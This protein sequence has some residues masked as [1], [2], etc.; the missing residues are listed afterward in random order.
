MKLKTSLYSKGLVI[1]N[2]KRYW[3]VSALYTLALFFAIPFNHYIQKF[4]NSFNYDSGDQEWIRQPIV[5]ELSFKGGSSQFFLLVIPIIIA[6]LVFRFMQ[7]NRSA[8]LYHSLPLT[9]TALYL[10]GVLS[11]LILFAAPILITTFIMFLLNWFSYLSAY[12]TAVLILSWLLKSLLFGIMFMSMGIFVGM[13]TGSSIAQLAFTYILNFLPMFIVESVRLNVRGLLFGFDT[14]SNVSFYDKMPMVMQFSANS[15]DF[16][17]ALIIIYILV[18]IALLIGGLFAF[19]LRKPETAGDI[20]TFSPIRPVFIY[21]VV[22]C[23]TLLGGAYFIQIA[24]SSFA[25]TIFGYFVS[26]LISYFIVQMIINKS[27]KILDTYKGYIG[28]ALVLVVLALGIKFDVFGYVNKIPDPSDVKEVYIGYDLYHWE[29]PEN[30]T[31]YFN[32]NDTSV[33]KE[34]QNIENITKLH[35]YILDRRSINGNHQYIAYKLNNGKKIIRKYSLDTENYAQVLKPIYES[36]EYKE[37]R[38]PIIKQNVNDLKYIELNDA[39][40]KRNGTVISD[41]AKLEGFKAAISKDIES[42]SY[43]DI[44]ADYQQIITANIVNTS[45]KNVFYNLNS[46]FVNTLAWLK[47]EGIYEDIALKAEN[48]D[49]ALLMSLIDKRDISSPATES[50]SVSIT[51]KKII[52]ELID[53]SLTVDQNQSSDYTV[54]FLDGTNNYLFSFAVRY[55]EKVSPELQSYIDKLK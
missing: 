48:V 19:K 6:V 3:W 33:Y 23:C 40:S 8:S 13:F 34:P 35:K 14:Y 10:T 49:T 11:A 44:I 4:S 46:N 31:N 9:R 53:L 18:T 5:R 41:K 47:S 24:N 7:K 55:D 52:Q 37:N 43:E 38:Y 22:A 50:K 45:D 15:D 26:S 27:F 12:Y 1:S 25:F 2:L 36:S 30:S 20:I 29:N 51:D 32:E 21:G 16:S 42:L 54:S 17:A 28:F 39:R